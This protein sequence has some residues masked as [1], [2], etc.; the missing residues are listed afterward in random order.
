MSLVTGIPE[1]L[2]E[3]GGLR[4]PFGAGRQI[5]RDPLHAEQFGHEKTLEQIAAQPIMEIPS[6]RKPRQ[7]TVAFAPPAIAT[8]ESA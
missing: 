3:M 1:I 4:H 6:W 5:E 8:I 2:L 7:V